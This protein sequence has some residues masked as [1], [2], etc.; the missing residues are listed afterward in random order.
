MFPVLAGKI[1][2]ADHAFPVTGESFHRLGVLGLIDEKVW[3]AAASQRLRFTLDRRYGTNNEDP[4]G[5][6]PH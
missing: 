2:E 5:Y 4:A 1:E 3:Q 6:D